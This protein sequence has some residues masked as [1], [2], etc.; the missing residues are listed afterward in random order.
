M[1][2]T[3]TN[4][5]EACRINLDE[6][7]YQLVVDMQNQ[8]KSESQHL[9]LSPYKLNNWIIKCFHQKYFK[10]EKEALI[11]AFFDRKE[12]VN[13]Y[14]KSLSNDDKFIQKMEEALVQLRKI[15]IT[16]EHNFVGD[17]GLKQRKIKKILGDEAVTNNSFKQKIE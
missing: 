11:E 7:V 3:K 12:F 13:E 1:S 5:K 10:K 17:N 6:E 16:G 15:G 9:K 8:I 14:L 2:K 4:N